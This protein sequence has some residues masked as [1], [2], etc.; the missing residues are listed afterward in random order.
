MGTNIPNPINDPIGI[1]V[2]LP[3]GHTMR[4]T[5]T[6]ILPIANLPV[7]ARQAHIFP[8]L[9]TGSLL[10]VGQLCD[11][12]CKA[13]FTAT[14]MNVTLQGNT[15]LK[16]AR[17]TPGLWIVDIGT[18]QTSTTP[19]TATRN[20]QQTCNA[21]IGA[22][23]IAERIAFYHAALFS[24][25][26][27]TWEAAIKAGRMTT[28][29]DLTIQQLR[30]HPPRSQAMVKGH[31][32]Q[33][34]ANIRSTKPKH[35][36]QPE[37]HGTQ[38]TTEAGLE[39]EEDCNPGQQPHEPQEDNYLYADCIAPTGKI[40]TDATGRF[41]L[42]SSNG[43]NYLLILYAY[44]ANF[45]HAEPMKNRTGQEMLAAYKRALAVL[46]KA[47]MH[48][49]LQLLDNEASKQLQLYIAKQGIDYQLVPPQIHRR[50][51]AER[52]IRTF[53]NHFIAGLS[54]TDPDFPLH[55][56][57]KLLPQALLTLNLLRGSRINPRL[58]A[59]AQIHGAFDYNRTPLAPPGIK[60]LVHEKPHTRETW[61]PHAVEGWSIGPAMH[62]YR[63]HRVWIKATQSERIA[64]T[65][66]W[67]PAVIPMPTGSSSDRILAAA[68]DLAQA[69]NRATSTTANTTTTTETRA[70][71]EQL[72][73]MF[74]NHGIAA[75]TG[76][77]PR[78]EAP[79]KG[80]TRPQTAEPTDAL[81]RVAYPQITAA[82][83]NTAEKPGETGNTTTYA[84]RTTN[85]NQRRRLA[86]KT[87]Q[88]QTDQQ[89]ANQEAENTALTQA[90]RTA[91]A[92]TAAAEARLR[93]LQAT[94]PQANAVIDKT[95]G[96][97]LEYRQVIKGP[98]KD[99]WLAGGGK[100]IPEALQLRNARTHPQRQSPSGAHRNLRQIRSELPAKQ[101]RTAPGENHGRRR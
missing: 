101:R 79:P 9:A 93:T 46:D 87:K 24:P 53:K 7:K 5:H 77:L 54:S 21:A 57:D 33:L 17:T 10:S 16:G 12:G 38:T 61:A 66:E 56:W 72:T 91:Q 44:D 84:D 90:I 78:V 37:Q 99:T 1:Q 34:R 6:A 51:A 50:N 28:W 45:I 13:T 36:N 76:G 64:D 31:M 81:P 92:E 98:D 4:S 30:S 85:A 80:T 47:G 18:P 2:A 82:V 25:A 27:S 69:I 86:K 19:H 65:L 73:T 62:H 35:S 15:V 75:T 23:K 26:L 67:F 89:K 11:Q 3:N 14:T 29:P 83:S 42:P 88:Q 22:P 49:K 100:R 8:A 41:I 68:A 97:T 71:L 60:V 48:P 58:S 74:A 32:D 95:T 40:Y 59:Q 70:A 96:E 63:C 39:T 94:Q 52:A 20:Q 55:L 43:N